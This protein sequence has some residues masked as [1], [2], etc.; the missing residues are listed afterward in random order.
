LKGRKKFKV[1][2]K[3]RRK[4]WKVKDVLKAKVEF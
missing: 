4:K 1:R 2:K 3:G